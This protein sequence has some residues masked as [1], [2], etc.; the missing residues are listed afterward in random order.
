MYISSG[1]NRAGA[2]SKWI[3]LCSINIRDAI[4][5]ELNS[6]F[7]I[8]FFYLI[9]VQLISKVQLLQSWYRTHNLSRLQHMLVLLRHYWPQSRYDIPTLKMLVFLTK[10]FRPDRA[11]A[12]QTAHH[13][14]G[15]TAG[16]VFIKSYS[17]C[18]YAATVHWPC[19]RY[20]IT[21]IS[22]RY[23][24]YWSMDSFIRLMYA[25]IAENKKL[26]SFLKWLYL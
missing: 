20:N 26:I 4:I 5:K 22:A 8:L 7:Y 24:L 11:S 23:D 13:N 1:R 14:G 19:D 9:I 25:R 2:A 17:G 3:N 18:H 10:Q 16:L 15:P 21:V 12:I 6:F